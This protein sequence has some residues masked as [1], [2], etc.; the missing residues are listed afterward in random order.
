MT[1]EAK[2]FLHNNVWIIILGIVVLGLFLFLSPKISRAIVPNIE[3]RD[4]STF[5][6]KVVK[7]KTVDSQTYWEFRE[8]YSPGVFIVNNEGLQDATIKSFYASLP[9]GFQSQPELSF[10]QFKS[11][12]LTSIDGLTSQTSIKEIVNHEEVNASKIV[13]QST[14]SL[15]YRINEK[16][17]VLILLFTPEQM[18]QTNGFWNYQK[19]MD[20]INN[21]NWV[22]TSI[23]SLP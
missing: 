20:V 15:L 17:Y 1:K 5:Q 9:E 8:F 12:L 23:I 14:T 13:S 2:H 19:D 3:S 16:K 22:S 11:P 6:E 10:S 18:R 21:R 4:W 7:N